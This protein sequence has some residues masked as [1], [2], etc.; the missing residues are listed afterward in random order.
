M[1]W[2]RADAIFYSEENMGIGQ[3]EQ[4]E[5]EPIAIRVDTIVTFNVSET[6]GH[7]CI[8]TSSGFDIT[9]KMTFEE[10]EKIVCAPENM[11]QW[12]N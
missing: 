4:K 8:R 2:L 7:T 10:V 5:Y 1:R 12:M 11:K 3:L 9:I 6:K